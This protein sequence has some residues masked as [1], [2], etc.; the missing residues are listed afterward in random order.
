[1]GGMKRLILGIATACTALATPAAASSQALEG[2]WANPHKSIIVNVA[3]CGAA[4]C[5]TV[6]WASARNKA[7]VAE[8]GRQLVGMRILTDLRPQGEGVY[9]GRAVEPKRNISGSATVTQINNDVMLVKGCAIGGF[10]IC[11]EQRW[12]RVS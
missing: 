8:D 5:G 2:R 11:K 6:S 7:K 4:Y 12:T 9:K 3:K 1:M 10:L